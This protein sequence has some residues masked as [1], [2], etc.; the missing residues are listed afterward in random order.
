MSEDYPVVKSSHAKYT[1]DFIDSSYEY[2]RSEAVRNA[3]GSIECKDVTKTLE[4]RVQK[5]K[6]K[7]GVMMVGLGGNNGTTLA[8]GIIANRKKLTWEADLKG[9]KT[10]N[11]IGS[12][13]EVGTMKIGTDAENKDIFVPLK[14]VLPT[15][16]ASDVVLGGWD[17]HH[18]TMAESAK[19]SK[20]LATDLQ[21]QLH[22]DL[23]DWV[24]LKGIYRPGWIAKNQASRANWTKEGTIKQQLDELRNDIKTFKTAQGLEKVLVFWSGNTERFANHTAGIHDT[25]ANLLTAIEKGHEEIAPSVLYCVAAILE[26][27]TFINGS[28]QNTICEGLLKMAQEHGTYL[29]GDD[30]KTG[31][32]KIKSVLADW[33]ISS[34]L[35]VQSIVSYNHL[36]NNDGMNLN[37]DAQFRSKEISKS[38]VVLDAIRSNP[39]L[40]KEDENPDHVVVIKYV[41]YVGDSKRA[42]DEYTSELFLGGNNTIVMHNTC[43]D[44]LLAAP[45][46][47][48]LIIL[49]ELCERITVKEE[50]KDF[51]KCFPILSILSIFLKAPKAMP[52]MSV[53]NAFASQRAALT[54]FFRALVGMKPDNHLRLEERFPISDMSVNLE[55]CPSSSDKQ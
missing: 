12:M 2:T 39:I 18:R 22:D 36:G 16:N 44:S 13:M 32:T 43:E 41:P 17:I 47:M 29:G 28:P 53:V 3:D 55:N 21:H 34:G 19:V 42:L 11:W 30:L 49:S 10:A 35:K 6:G 26:G 15:T 24:P 33:L 54:N 45:L 9:T 7:L 46:M 52:G 25:A 4:F 48:D 14:S 23:K 1:E 38:D 37:E 8:G 31:Q 40:Y 27:C 5:K 50:G 20:V 51:R